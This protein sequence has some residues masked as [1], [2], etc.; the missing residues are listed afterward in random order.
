MGGKSDQ[1]ERAE[2]LTGQ[3]GGLYNQIS[4]QNFQIDNPF[5][6][7]DLPFNYESMSKMIDEITSQNVGQVNKQANTQIQQGQSDLAERMA[8]EGVTSSSIRESG[9]G[10][11]RSDV[12][13]NRSNLIEQLYGRNLEGKLGAMGEQNKYDFAATGQEGQFDLANIQ[14]LMKKYGMLSGNLG[15]QSGLLGAYDAS[16]TLDDIFASINAASGFVPLFGGGGA[17]GGGG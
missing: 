7:Y 13:R 12:N 10:G 14:N 5:K 15:S 17:K 1:Q 6:G 4:G 9:F 8:G 11:V 2:Q 3:Y 16:T